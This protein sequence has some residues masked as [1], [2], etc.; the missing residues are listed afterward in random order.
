MQRTLLA[1]LVFLSFANAARAASIDIGCTNSQG[2][3]AA[4]TSAINS[5]NAA[6][7]STDINLVGGCT[8]LLTTVDNYWYGP[9]GL[10]AISAE[11]AI[12]GNGATLARSEPGTPAFR[13]LYVA[14]G[15][16]GPPLGSL[17]MR[18]LMLTG[19]LAVGGYSGSGGGGAGM[20]GAI[21]SQGRV[22]LI[23]V[24]LKSNYARG[25][26]TNIGGAGGGGIGGNALGYGTYNTSSG[27]A[28]FGGPFP[29]SAGALGGLGTEGAGGGGGFMSVQSG[30]NAAGFF[31]GFGGGSGGLGGN[32]GGGAYGGT[33][34]DG[35]GGGGGIGGTGGNG[36]NSGFGGKGSSIIAGSDGSVG[37]GAGGGIGG[38]GGYGYGG[39]GGGFGGGGGTG[40]NAGGDGGFGGGGGSGSVLGGNGGFGAGF[41]TSFYLG[42]GGGGAG[43]GGAIFQHNGWLTAID[44]QIMQNVAS[45][46][47]G[48][49]QFG[50][51]LGGA[52]FNLNGCVALYRTALTDNQV[53][54]GDPIYGPDGNIYNLGYLHADSGGLFRS[55]ARLYLANSTLSGTRNG[56]FPVSEVV[57]LSPP[58]LTNGLSNIATATVTVTDVL[59]A[60]DFESALDCAPP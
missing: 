11:I 3:T 41:G 53:L 42:G 60:E 26:Q 36:G 1:E 8:Y 56:Q 46:G 50:T 45:G 47:R 13:L 40:G 20:G 39:G 15:L 16:N 33:A 37:G 2:D 38:G 18:D 27:G 31:G 29:A 28:G 43:M 23:N 17:T 54:N 7:S 22:K 14:G 52:I 21:F 49:A 55:D 44:S 51:G 12:N 48:G 25:G 35:G 6:S 19:G 5:A 32:G 9:N 57:N 4:L 10:P 34:G 58:S 59:F 24:T 30:A